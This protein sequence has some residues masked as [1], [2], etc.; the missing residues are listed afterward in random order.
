VPAELGSVGVNARLFG[1]FDQE[2][3]QLI[4]VDH[5]VSTLLSVLCTLCRV[6]VKKN[7]DAFCQLC[8]V[9]YVC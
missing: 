9:I 2:G 5:P 1:A 6:P 3:F 4:P 8:F 7:R